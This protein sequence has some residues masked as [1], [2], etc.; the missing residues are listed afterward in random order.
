MN[1]P[2]T[3]RRS[4]T[5]LIIPFVAI[6]GA[7]G[8]GALFNRN[9]PKPVNVEN[10]PSL[11][12]PK[13]GTGVVA[14]KTSFGLNPP[15]RADGTPVLKKIGTDD[16]GPVAWASI[17]F[18]GS[19]ENI[20]LLR[21][22]LSSGVKDEAGNDWPSSGAWDGKTFYCGIARGYSSVPK[23]LTATASV[24]GKE[25]AKAELPPL[26]KPKPL[27][28]PPLTPPWK[29]LVTE[30]CFQTD[31]PPKRTLFYID[32]PLE[33]GHI[34]AAA[35][36][37]TTY[38]QESTSY[39]NTVKGSEAGTYDQM[40]SFPLNHPNSRGKAYIDV[41]E[42]A[43]EHVHKQLHFKSFVPG[44]KFGLPWIIGPGSPAMLSEG[45]YFRLVGN[46]KL[47]NRAPEHQRRK[48]ILS[49]QASGLVRH[50]KATLVSPTSARSI[51]FLI[52]A[53]SFQVEKVTPAVSGPDWQT[54]PLEFVLDI[55][56]DVYHQ[57]RKATVAVDMSSPK[58]REAVSGNVFSS[59]VILKD[60][61]PNFNGGVGAGRIVA[62]AGFLAPRFLVHPIIRQ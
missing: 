24:D 18:I 22:Y 51:P 20:D 9:R 12:I 37:G 25:L 40:I 47:P 55:E 62:P 46:D 60:S 3:D 2:P 53:D 11:T 44:D 36:H 15:L 21:S 32:A 23:K 58:K 27:T 6:A 33:P 5:A 30:A 50:A 48:I 41:V 54:G 8:L 61:K 7:L 45:V 39:F 4:S 59:H 34:L 16:A 31:A 26:P 38:A 14:G 13:P 28:P 57:V 1:R 49:M 29:G 19:D 56:A 43:P 35:I 10:I 42:F 52:R 17:Q